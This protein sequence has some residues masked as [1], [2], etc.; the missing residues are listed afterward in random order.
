MITI[1]SMPGLKSEVYLCN[2]SHM[3]SEAGKE[4]DAQSSTSEV[5]SLQTLWQQETGFASSSFTSI[6][7]YRNC[8]VEMD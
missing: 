3:Q 2:G 7:D 1:E 4:D 8:N 6:C 5:A